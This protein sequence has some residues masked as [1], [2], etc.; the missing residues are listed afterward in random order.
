[1]VKQGRMGWKQVEKEGRMLKVRE[2][3]KSFANVYALDDVR[4]CLAQ[5]WSPKSS[6]EHAFI[7]NYAKS[8]FGDSIS[9][10]NVALFETESFVAIP[11]IGSLV[12]GWLLIVPKD[13]ALC[14]GALS[15]EKKQELDVF[16]KYVA[17]CLEFYFGPVVMFEHGPIVERS[18]IGCSV[19]YAHLHLVPV[20]WDLY[21]YVING[22]P[23]IQ[24]HHVNGLEATTQYYASKTP[25]LYLFQPHISPVHF[26]GTG[27]IPSQLFRRVIA[28]QLGEPSAYDW[29][30]FPHFE[31]IRQTIEILQKN[32]V[33]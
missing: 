22:F 16:A 11:S 21:A 14:I 3:H 28:Y 15:Q 17:K 24:W 12:P 19:D 2:L 5:D 26:I 33:A 8:V 10:W 32:S 9:V 1:M 18:C 31:T 20:P 7:S 23:S 13:P 30:I 4:V 6:K 27:E 25:Y 29:K